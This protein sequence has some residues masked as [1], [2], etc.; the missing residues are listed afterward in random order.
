MAGGVRPVHGGVQVGSAPARGRLPR[1]AH[2]ARAALPV[3][4]RPPAAGG[5]ARVE[6]DGAGEAGRGRAR[7]RDGDVGVC[8]G[9]GDA[10]HPAGPAP[11]AHRR[12]DQPPGV[13]A[14]A[15]VRPPPPTAAHR[16]GCRH[17][18]R[19]PARAAAPELGPYVVPSD[20]PMFRGSRGSLYLTAD[21]SPQPPSDPPP[22]PPWPDSGVGAGARAAGGAGCPGGGGGGAP[23]GPTAHPG[24][25]GG[26][27]R[28]AG[29]RATRGGP[30][31]SG[32]YRHR[33][34]AQAGART[35]L[36][37]IVTVTQVVMCCTKRERLGG[38]VHLPGID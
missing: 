23:V 16:P 20:D 30:L 11:G 18:G 9:G 6:T 35:R 36:G 8:E 34:R 1:D 33:R 22:T 3:G 25:G 24:G 29:G 37:G 7:L 32:H 19:Q 5:A 28:A 13:R 14:G 2:R 38:L 31:R 27:T 10:L 26:G 15:A 4:L 21:T 17:A 12:G